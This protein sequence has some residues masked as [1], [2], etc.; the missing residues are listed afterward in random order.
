[1]SEIRVTTISDAAGTGPVT[2]TKQSAAK[3]WLNFNGTGTIAARD[4]FNVASLVDNGSGNYSVNFSNSFSNANYSVTQAGGYQAGS[5]AFSIVTYNH[6]SGALPT[7][8]QYSLLTDSG[9]SWGPSDL[10]YVL[11]NTHGDLA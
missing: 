2:L 1:M 11:T 9:L 3:A 8:S 7:T 10:D 5:A 6:N 4:S